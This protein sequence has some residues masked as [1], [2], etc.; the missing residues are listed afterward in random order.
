MIAALYVMKDG[1]YSELKNVDVWYEQRD[2]RLYRGPHKVIA[3][4]PC[5]RWGRYWGGGPMLHGTKNQKL[6]GD[7]K[8]CFSHALIHVGLAARLEEIAIIFMNKLNY[9]ALYRRGNENAK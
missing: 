1:P 3:H 9:D 7:D 6:L 5:E 4:P 8:L 2:A